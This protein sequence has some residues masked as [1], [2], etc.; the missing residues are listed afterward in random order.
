MVNYTSYFDKLPKIKY[1]INRSLVNPKYE[2]VTNIFFRIRYIKDVINNTSSYYT[3]EVTDGDTIEILAE[4][5]YGDAGAGWMIILA[6]QIIDPQW[7]W[8]LNY[9]EFNKFIIGKYGSIENAQITNHHYEMV[10]EKTVQPDNITTVKRYTVG[11]NKLTDNN[12]D[13]PHNY[14][15][16]YQPNPTD[17]GSLAFTQS[18]NTY[19]VA[20]KTVTEVI[21]GEA[22]TNYQYEEA[23]ND[24]R[25]LIKVVKKEYYARILNE[26]DNLTDYTEPYRRRVR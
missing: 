3:L 26:F 22:I 13:V 20:G 2:S 9:D 21:K 24:Q 7:D 6:N 14:Y 12:L 18:V 10:V 11:G 19:E 5:I 17:P 1:D 15:F 23:L 16:P 25:R 4:K 8:P